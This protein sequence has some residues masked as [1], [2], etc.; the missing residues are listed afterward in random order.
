M[1]L[2]NFVFH[3]YIYI[4]YHNIIMLK[5]INKNIKIY[6]LQWHSDNAHYTHIQT[7]PFFSSKS[8]H[9][10]VKTYLQYH[11]KINMSHTN[12]YVSLSRGREAYSNKYYDTDRITAVSCDGV[13]YCRWLKFSSAQNSW[14]IW[15]GTVG[16]V[17]PALSA[18]STLCLRHQIRRRN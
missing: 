15:Q 14:V 1:F 8:K 16:V 10:H 18:T 11:N 17:G 5:I 13:C 7:G 3:S 12:I 2:F 4:L 6:T 9:F